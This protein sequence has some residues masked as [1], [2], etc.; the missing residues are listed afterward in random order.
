MS[1][2]KMYSNTSSYLQHFRVKEWMRVGPL[3]KN[4]NKDKKTFSAACA[5]A[6]V[7]LIDVF[8][9]C[10]VTMIILEP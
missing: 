3:S 8:F 10:N 5:R 2:L 7:P 4:S 1:F 6:P 9:S